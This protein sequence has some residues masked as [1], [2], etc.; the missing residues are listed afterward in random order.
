LQR[1]RQ[2]NGL[3]TA[4]QPHRDDKQAATAVRVRQ[5]IS[6]RLWAVQH[7]NRPRRANSRLY[8]KVSAMDHRPAQADRGRTS[9]Q[10]A[11]AAPRASPAHRALHP[12]RALGR[13]PMAPDPPAADADS[14]QQTFCST[15]WSIMASAEVR[16]PDFAGSISYF[17]FRYPR[18]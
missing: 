10:A 9:R 13:V 4:P 11:A 3:R 2:I 8:S 12:L 7:I 17:F 5:L 6:V 18:R 1:V 14:D 15:A 16:A